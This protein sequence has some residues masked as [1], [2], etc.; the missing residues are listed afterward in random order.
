MIQHEMMAHGAHATGDLPGHA[1][2]GLLLSA[3][4]LVWMFR[5]RRTPE[6][7]DVE[8]IDSSQAAGGFKIIVAIVALV[9]HIPPDQWDAMAKAMAW[10]HMAMFIPFGLAG[11]VD[12]LALRGKLDARATFA[13]HAFVFANIVV[14][15]AGHGNPG[16]VEATAH[17]L[18]TYV[19]GVTALALLGET[20][21]GSRHLRWIR[22]ASVLASGL[23]FA[24]TG[25]ILFV[26]GWELTDPANEMLVHVAWAATML[27]SV[28][29]TIVMCCRRVSS[30]PQ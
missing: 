3:W 20:V 8:P 26:S 4:A 14:M 18:L 15:L 13:V 11:A 30:A 5:F 25:W 24:V 22:S 16:G 6:T 27:I 10:Q 29:I 28:S 12:I 19:L 23:W 7:N 21:Q 2:P 9:A 17:R 1:L